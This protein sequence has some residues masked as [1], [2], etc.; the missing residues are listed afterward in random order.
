[1]R[2]ND[3]KA[4]TETDAFLDELFS[5]DAEFGWAC[6]KPH[7]CM[8]PSMNITIVKQEGEAEKTYIKSLISDFNEKLSQ[9]LDGCDSL[10]DERESRNYTF[11]KGEL[12]TRLISMGNQLDDIIKEIEEHT[13]AGVMN[14]SITIIG[15]GVP[16]GE[17]MF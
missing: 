16:M 5:E 13:T 9:I 1:M 11:T 3:Y 8:E 10:A 14:K 4:Y 17:P 6:E 12:I 15:G 7:S 2:Y